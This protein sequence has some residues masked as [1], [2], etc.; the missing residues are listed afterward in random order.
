MRWSVIAI[1]ASACAGAPA[2]GP[3]AGQER[4]ACRPADA[5]DVGLECWSARC[6]R[7]PPAACP[8]VARRLASYQVGNY[9]TPEEIAPVIVALTGAC[10]R[11]QLTAREGRCLTD[12]VGEDELLACPRVLVPELEAKLAARRAPPPE[13]PRDPAVDP[14]LPVDPWGPPV[15]ASGACDRYAALLDTYA[16]C[17]NLPAVTR[18]LTRRSNAAMRLSWRATAASQRAAVEAS[19]ADG[20]AA[21]T[22]LLAQL[23]CAP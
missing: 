11:A 20:A 16:A 6:V 19:C 3:P 4:G 5:C 14:V 15:T 10:E 9:A 2:A 18:L 7:P 17:P 12:A 21:L 23:G 8:A 22:T 1:A 13:P